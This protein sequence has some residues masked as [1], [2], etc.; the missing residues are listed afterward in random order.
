MDPGTMVERLSDR[1][2]NLVSSE[3]GTVERHK[4]LNATI[5]WSYNLLTIE[6]KI[7]FKRLGVFSGGFDL[8]AVE[9]VCVDRTFPGEY[10]LDLLAGLIDRS[11]VN[12]IR[13]PG[14]PIRYYLLETIHQY[15]LSLL[16][17]AEENK[18][19]KKH[20]AYYFNVAEEAY[21]ERLLSQASWMG[22]LH[23]EHDNMLAALNWSEH[24]DLRRFASMAGAIA[25][26]WA[27]SKN[28]HL[29][30]QILGKI[31]SMGIAKSATKARILSGY[32]WT[33]AGNLDQYSKLMDYAKQIVSIR[34]RLGDLNEEA[35]ALAEMALLYFGC[36]DDENALKNASKAYEMAQIN[37]DPGVLLY[38]MIAV[39]Q[40]F[41][42][43]KKLDDAR[44]TAT[45]MIVLAEKYN[46]LNVRFAGH[47]NLADCAMMEGKFH[48]AERAYARALEIVIRFGD[49]H[50]VFTDLLGMTMA[51]A[52]MGRHEKALRLM[53]AVNEGS[54]KAG[55]E[56]LENMRMGFW[57]ELVKQHIVGTRKKM[58]KE[59][60]LKYES[61]GKAMDLDE[62][63]RYAL[64]FHRD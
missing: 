58:G 62:A 28:Y 33:L 53:G 54:R 60:T 39:S 18:L 55:T 19:R 45:K 14:Q 24:Y 25:W 22:R 34:H 7:L 31:V 42:H 49:M 5:D 59:L 36:G 48:E 6:E 63:V 50:Y 35:V 30:Q 38:C 37:N 8:I 27:R 41:V 3:P 4:T 51:I 21:R 64:D 29:G 61:E 9:E 17:D 47:H 20:F 40:G 43:L 32:G 44:S 1:F 23:M 13:N 26:F 10:I 16:K 12:T 52:G 57:Q 2:S 56:S 11:M 15:A 46:N